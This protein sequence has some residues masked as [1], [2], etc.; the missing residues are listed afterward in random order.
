MIYCSDWKNE[1]NKMIQNVFS[2]IDADR[3]WDVS[4]G[5][6]RISQDYLKKMRRDLR[7]S[8]IVNFPYDNIDGYYQYPENIRR[9]MESMMV[10]LLEKYM[11][12]EK[13]FT[14]KKM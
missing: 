12:K 1:Y 5:T 4:V 3:L 14:W 6:F 2:H 11:P 7:E 13:I 8:A 9:D 10:K